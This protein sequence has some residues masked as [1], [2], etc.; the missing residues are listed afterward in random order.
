MIIICNDEKKEISPSA[1]IAGLLAELG[2]AP[3][4]VFVECNG[5]IIRRD[6]YE[7]HRLSEGDRLELIRFVGGG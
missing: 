4:T 3:D 6:N 1:T 5:V 2:V 7:T